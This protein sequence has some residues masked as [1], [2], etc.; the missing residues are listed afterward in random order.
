MKYSLKM[1]KFI[2]WLSFFIFIFSTI[3][4]LSFI[5][6]IKLSIAGIE[7]VVI[8]IPYIG[9]GLYCFV[10]IVLPK[11]LIIWDDFL[12]IKNLPRTFTKLTFDEVISFTSSDKEKISPWKMIRYGCYSNQNL[13]IIRTKSKIYYINLKNQSDFEHICLSIRKNDSTIN[14]ED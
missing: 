10:S 5:N 12:Y 7:D 2:W 9:L 14:G 8:T 11:E 1:P 4:F 6:F 3:I 13:C